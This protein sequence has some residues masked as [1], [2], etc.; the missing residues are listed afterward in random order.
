QNPS[1]QV[2]NLIRQFDAT[3]RDQVNPEDFTRPRRQFLES[4]I[5]DGY[6]A[7]IQGAGNL[8]QE[9]SLPA[10]SLDHHEGGIRANDLQRNGRRSPARPEIN[11]LQWVR[12]YLGRRNQ[13]LDEQTIDRRIGITGQRQSS[14]I[15]LGIPASEHLAVQLELRQAHGIERLPG[16]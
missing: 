12:A 10:S 1:D 4:A 8:A 15:D 7:E 9:S 13:R 6:I 11:P 16:D 14:E 5:Y 2:E 3:S